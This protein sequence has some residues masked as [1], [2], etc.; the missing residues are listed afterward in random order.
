M[1]SMR[2]FFDINFELVLFASGLV[3]FIVGLAVSLQSRRYSRLQLARSLGWLSVFGFAHG[4]HEWG[5]LFIPI[6]ALYMNYPGI[7]LLLLFQMLLMGTAFFALFAFG[8]DLVRDKWPNL[9]LSPYLMALIWMLTL[10]ILD[11]GSDWGMGWLQQQATIWAK[12][13]LAFPGA[14]LAAYGLRYQ[15]ERQ[16][17][18]L[19]LRRIYNTTLVA[20]ITLVLYAL[21]AGLFVPY[22]DFFPANRFNQ[23]LLVRYTGIP[24]P[25]FL[26]LI[27]LVL[28]VT[29]TR[30]LEVF[31]L[32][33]GR[34][35]EQMRFEQSLS[36]ERDRIGRE[37]HDGAI[38]MVYTA[39]L[40]IESARRR[41]EDDVVLSQRLDRA[42]TA[43][44]ETVASLRA[45]MN[46][47]RAESLASS[48]ADGLRER[49]QDPR[50]TSLMTVEL[51]LEL[52]DTTIFNPVQTT[53]ILAIVGEAL[54]N[55]ARHARPSFALVRAA[56]EN[57]HFVLTIRD[58]G[59][60][61]APHPSDESGYGLRNMRDR[62]RLLGG[63]LSIESEKGKGSCVELTVPWEL[64]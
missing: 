17:K 37:L 5:L 62:A 1:T 22:G 43:L 18:A 59:S 50:L 23:Y 8:A 39:G 15:A 14:L 61:F 13:L 3:F 58:D 12:Y 54:T 35:I 21:F 36:A 44:N 33:T 46:D 47:L 64:M 45:N 60:G 4:L 40:I 9:R 51:S 28:A 6:Q 63:E 56:S 32:E 57:G 31:D 16:I 30:V 42:M 25:V 48:L 26:S 41:V 49:T 20:S 7:S 11:M 24:Q 34:L 10:L 29:V 2:D 27:G 53:H 38:Q 52:P 55:A 19:N